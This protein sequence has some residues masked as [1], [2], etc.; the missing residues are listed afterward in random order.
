MHV[1]QRFRCGPAHH[2]MYPLFMERY[3]GCE[4][5]PMRRWAAHGRIVAATT[6]WATP[7]VWQTSIRNQQGAQEKVQ[8][9]LYLKFGAVA[10]PA[11]KCI[12]KRNFRKITPQFD[13]ITRIIWD[14]GFESQCR[15]PLC[16]AK[17]CLPSGIYVLSHQMTDKDQ[18]FLR[19]P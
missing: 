16:F 2:V 5:F 10:P 19:A 12:W 11:L 14:S 3:R 8:A 18:A 6:D 13:V 4:I 9:E 15:Y 1:H 17:I 7:W